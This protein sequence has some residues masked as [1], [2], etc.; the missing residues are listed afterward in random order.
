MKY[1]WMSWYWL[2][3]LVVGFGLPEGI[4]LGT[5]NPQNTLSYQVWHIEGTG[6]TFARYWIAAFLGWLFIHMVFN[7][8][9]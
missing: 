9:R 5:G 3:W 7:T 6:M 4:A 1:N 2:F 8:F